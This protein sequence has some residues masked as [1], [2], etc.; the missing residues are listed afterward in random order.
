MRWVQGWMLLA[1]ARML[2]ESKPAEQVA[3]SQNG[4][5][6]NS[7]AARSATEPVAQGCAS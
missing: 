7:P 3:S 1:L 4:T 6:R 2:E 5:D